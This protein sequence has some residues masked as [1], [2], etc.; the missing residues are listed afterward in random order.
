[1]SVGSEIFVS[2]SGSSR[3]LVFWLAL[4]RGSELVLEIC[5]VDFRKRATNMQGTKNIVIIRN[6]VMLSN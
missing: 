6:D 3:H 1:M 5:R 4:V 2:Y